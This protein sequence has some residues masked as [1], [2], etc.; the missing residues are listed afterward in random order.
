MHYKMFYVETIGTSAA[1]VIRIEKFKYIVHRHDSNNRKFS[2]SKGAVVQF[3]LRSMQQALLQEFA[4]LAG[5]VLAKNYQYNMYPQK[6]LFLN[7]S[8]QSLFKN[9]STR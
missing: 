9:P 3:S 6:F 4:V 8:K 7:T 2:A 1:K 5:S